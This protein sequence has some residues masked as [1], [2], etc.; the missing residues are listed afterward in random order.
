MPAHSPECR[1]KLSALPIEP[2]AESYR[3]LEEASDA[4]RQAQEVADYQAIGVQCREA[5]LAFAA[6]AQMALPWTGNSEAPKKA[7]MKGWTDHICAATMPG[8]THETRRHLFMALLD[9]A[10]KL[11]PWLTYSKGSKWHDAEAGV[12]AT[13]NAISLATSAVS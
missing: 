9:S 10:Y 6:A 12:S 4:L 1:Q 7:D 13:E 3:Y 5:L 2:L 8:S 11:T